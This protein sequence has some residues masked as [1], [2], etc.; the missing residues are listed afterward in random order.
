MQFV[1]MKIWQGRV[2]PTSRR[3]VIIADNISQHSKASHGQVPQAM[4]TDLRAM[5][6]NSKGKNRGTLHSYSFTAAGS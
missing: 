3:T 6:E 4:H 5:W 1:C 2:K